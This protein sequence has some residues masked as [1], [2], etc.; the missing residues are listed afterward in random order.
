MI[1][2]SIAGS[3]CGYSTPFAQSKSNRQRFLP[4]IIHIDSKPNNTS[5]SVINELAEAISLD[6]ETVEILVLIGICCP[7]KASLEHV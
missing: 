5:F 7:W 4:M 2:G 1:G 3:C 6:F